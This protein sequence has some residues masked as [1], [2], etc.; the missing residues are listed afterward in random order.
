MASKHQ[1]MDLPV[2]LL[3]MMITYIP[4]RDL[5]NLRTIKNRELY[6]LINKEIRDRRRDIE[7][8]RN[9]RL[10]AEQREYRAEQLR[11]F[12]ERGG[13][14]RDPDLEEKLAGV[15]VRQNAINRFDPEDPEG[16]FNFRFHKK[17]GCSCKK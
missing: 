14:P 1:L 12:I 8:R 16:L 15:V 4:S 17:G 7:T 13:N 11:R 5:L 10:E 2:E 9:I 3:Q 6:T